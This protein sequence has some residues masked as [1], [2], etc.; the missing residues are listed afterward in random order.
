MHSYAQYACFP[1]Q[2]MCRVRIEVEK[3]DEWY[4]NDKARLIYS[5]SF[6]RLGYKTQVFVNY[7]GDHYRTR[8]THSLEVAQISQI[9]AKEL[10]VF[11]DLAQAVALAHDIGHPPFGH[12]GEEALNTA[13]SEYG[14][15]DHN[16][17]TF[18]IITQLE[19]W[20]GLDGLNMTRHALEGI[21]KHNGPVIASSSLGIMLDNLG[22]DPTTNA[23]IEAQIAALADDIAYVAHDVED[24]LRCGALQLHQLSD[25]PILSEILN[26]GMLQ[27]NSVSNALRAKLMQD[28]LLHTTEAVK[29]LECYQDVATHKEQ[30][31][32]FSPEYREGVL[33]IKEFLMRSLYRDQIV[34]ETMHKGQAVIAD[35]FAYYMDDKR[36][37][38][39]PWLT[40]LEQCK[41]EICQATIVSEYIAGMTDRFA[42]DEHRNI[43]KDKKI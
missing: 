24:G 14:G 11:Q 29:Y 15:F 1:K 40:R 7:A 42:H 4:I 43:E 22:I 34:L 12:A 9:I 13:M 41:D 5:G 17:H 20:Q 16:V 30:I 10:G 18:K 27:K 6:R 33:R 36:R 19:N 21:A 37:L 35:L 26:I 32:G 31:V 25:L 8:L 28:A 38:P 2:S 39:K 23:S 3:E